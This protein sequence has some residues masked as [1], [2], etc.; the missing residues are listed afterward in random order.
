ML[1]IR[2]SRIEYGARVNPLSAVA[3]AFA[4]WV[5]PDLPLEARSPH[6]KRRYRNQRRQADPLGEGQACTWRTQLIKVAARVV[7]STR[8]IRV[9]LSAAWP[10][11]SQYQAVSRAV[12][13]FT[14]PALHTG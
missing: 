6:Q 2:P 7:V 9:L 3:A 14:P 5:V 4:Q 8:R 11:W 12:L 1:A 13:G 10:Y